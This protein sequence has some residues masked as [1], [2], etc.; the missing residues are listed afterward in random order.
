VGDCNNP[1]GDMDADKDKD[2]DNDNENN[3]DD[4]LVGRLEFEC[5][6][7]HR[8]RASTFLCEPCFRPPM[9]G[10]LAPDLVPDPETAAPDVYHSRLRR[11]NLDRGWT[12]P[13]RLAAHVSRPGFVDFVMPTNLKAVTDD[14]L[15]S[16]MPSTAGSLAG[17]L[18]AFDVGLVVTCTPL[19]LFVPGDPE[20]TR[21]AVNLG[22]PYESSFI[23]RVDAAE[24]YAECMAAADR[25]VVFLHTPAPDGSVFRVQ[26]LEAMV[27]AA[28]AAFAAGK[29]VWTHC[30]AG[31]L[32]SWAALAAVLH[33][34]T[35]PGGA[36]SPGC[37]RACF[38]TARAP[39]P[40]FKVNMGRRDHARLVESICG[41]LRGRDERTVADSF[42]ESHV[43]P[44]LWCTHPECPP[45]ADAHEAACM[46]GVLREAE[47]VGRNLF[48]LYTNVFRHKHAWDVHRRGYGIAS[49]PHRMVWLRRQCA[50][51]LARVFPI[52]TLRAMCGPADARVL[53]ARHTLDGYVQASPCV[54]MSVPVPARTH[55][56]GHTPPPDPGFE[57][58]SRR[59]LQVL[60]ERA[61]EVV[62]RVALGD[63]G[64]G[65]EPRETLVIFT[66]G[67][68]MME[69]HARL[70]SWK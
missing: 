21:Y 46:A 31:L 6:L 1:H 37:P 47:D 48:D 62:G 70:E 60:V 13:R 5:S 44:W 36:P 64:D 8:S 27:A 2:K 38:E 69:A 66:G 45:P 55:A 51:A 4:V 67:L 32:R 56:A 14:V 7:S 40:K 12:C 42:F 41:C 20:S 28:N 25:G 3:D 16:H 33:R 34:C 50:G 18:R 43:E 11:V 24:F 35:L 10:W 54:A 52:A 58:G 57:V 49:R 26:D 68:A 19:P 17:V 23:A 9:P 53:N 63:A 15:V 22:N 61:F 59:T 30:W 65:S 29:T 39:T